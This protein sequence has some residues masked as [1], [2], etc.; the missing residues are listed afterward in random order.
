EGKLHLGAQAFLNDKIQESYKWVLQQTLDATSF[1]P[2][3]FIT[4]MDPTI[5]A[6]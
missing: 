3:V 1:E 6:A 5:N 4:D 2:Y